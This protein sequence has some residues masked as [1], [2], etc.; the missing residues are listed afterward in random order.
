[1]T[2]R[3]IWGNPANAVG[4]TVVHGANVA[5]ITVRSSTQKGAISDC[6]MTTVPRRQIASVQGAWV[7]V[8]ARHIALASKAG[9]NGL[10]SAVG[11]RFRS[12]APIEGAGVIVVA[13]E[14]KDAVADLSR[15]QT[16]R[17]STDRSANHRATVNSDRVGG[18]PNEHRPPQ[19]PLFHR[20][21]RHFE[22]LRRSSSPTRLDIRKA[23]SNCAWITVAPKRSVFTRPTKN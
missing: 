6:L 13:R 19:H 5:V 7:T 4:K 3:R 9:N 22:S 16:R 23:P 17:R 21:S 11:V 12:T 18:Q 2:T 15:L 20:P 10:I 8:V 14:R 1:M